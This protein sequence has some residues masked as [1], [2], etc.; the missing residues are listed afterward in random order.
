MPGRYCIVCTQDTPG[1]PYMW[2]LSVSGSYLTQET[3]E[4]QLAEFANREDAVAG[5]QDHIR[6]TRETK[7]GGSEQGIMHSIALADE[8]REFTSPDLRRALEKHATKK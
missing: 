7:Q 5:C 3:R 1:S 2:A 8:W 4:D 6:F